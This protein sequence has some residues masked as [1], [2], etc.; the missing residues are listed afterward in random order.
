LP[1]REVLRPMTVDGR[2]GQVILVAVRP[3]RDMA[4]TA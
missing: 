3:P 1:Q 4:F 2:Q